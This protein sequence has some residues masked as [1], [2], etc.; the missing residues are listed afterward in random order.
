MKIRGRSKHYLR[1]RR[2]EVRNTGCFGKV[3]ELW[4]VLVLGT[5]EE[6]L[7]IDVESGSENIYDSQSPLDHAVIA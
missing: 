5:E 1:M 2:Y 4:V 3:T 7:K 6:A